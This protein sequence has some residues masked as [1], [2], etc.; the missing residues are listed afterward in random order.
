MVAGERAS[1]R[2]AGAADEV[3]SDASGT[4]WSFSWDRAWS[5]ER[6]TENPVCVEEAVHRQTG[7]HRSME[8][9]ARPGAGATFNSRSGRPTCCLLADRRTR[10]FTDFPDLDVHS[11]SHTE[12]I[13]AFPASFWRPSRRAHECWAAGSIVRTKTRRFS[14]AARSTRHT[15]NATKGDDDRQPSRLRSPAKRCVAPTVEKVHP[16]AAPLA[17]V[18][19]RL[20]PRGHQSRQDSAVTGVLSQDKRCSI[21]GCGRGRLRPGWTGRT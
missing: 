14:P 15:H 5:G 6:G 1:S 7:G 18:D 20:R 10:Q 17:W 8:A 2:V 9:A 21:R 3:A 19:T 11:E 16:R 13:G 12:G 4:R